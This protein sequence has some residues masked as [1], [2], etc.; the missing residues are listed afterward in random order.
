LTGSPVKCNS[1]SSIW[2]L[3]DDAFNQQ[4]LDGSISEP[5]LWRENRQADESCGF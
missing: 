4:N 5:W 1:A 3:S 2:C